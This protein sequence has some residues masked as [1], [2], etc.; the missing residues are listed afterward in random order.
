MPDIGDDRIFLFKGDPEEDDATTTEEIREWVVSVLPETPE[1]AS[2]L[3]TFDYEKY[4]VEG[5][6]SGD[7]NV[8]S[9]V[10]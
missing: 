4:L 10:A 2:K 9:A 3:K 7:M 6:A 5:A 8:K 1:E